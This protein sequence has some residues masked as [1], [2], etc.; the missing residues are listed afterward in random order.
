MHVQHIMGIWP[1][2]GI[3]TWGRLG[4][5]CRSPAFS[6]SSTPM[7]ARELATF[8]RTHTAITL[9]DNSILVASSTSDIFSSAA[10]GTLRHSSTPAFFLLNSAWCSW[11]HCSGEDFCSDTTASAAER[12]LWRDCSDSATCAG[13]LSF[14]HPRFPPLQEFLL[15]S[16]EKGAGSQARRLCKHCLACDGVACTATEPHRQRGD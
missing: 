1:G 11:V 4:R 7:T 10:G 3:G 14:Y 15:L 2:A 12:H 16:S 13:T 5:C 6:T 9:T 8:P